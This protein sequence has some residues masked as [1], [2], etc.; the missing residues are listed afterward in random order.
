MVD[1]H[2]DARDSSH[3]HDS[4]G[5]AETY[6]PTY[7]GRILV[8]S[9]P[10]C[11]SPPS[12]NDCA[13]TN[14]VRDDGAPLPTTRALPRAR[15]PAQSS[16]VQVKEDCLTEFEQMKIRSAYKVRHA[17]QCRSWPRT[18]TLCPLRP[19]TSSTR[20]QMTRSGSRSTAR[21]RVT[22]LS[23]PRRC[24]TATAATASLTSRSPPSRARRPTN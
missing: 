2:G 22:S 18:D 13:H 1:M 23:S 6:L 19:S 7:L 14:M 20:S 11:V 4:I 17:S 21:G 15:A 8:G 16:G 12:V 9:P 3:P 10:H 5:T 24:P